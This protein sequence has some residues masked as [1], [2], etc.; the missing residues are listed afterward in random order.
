MGIDFSFDARVAGRYDAQRAHPPAVS[1]Q[2]GAT[3]AAAAGPGARVLEIGVGTGRIAWPVA[4]AGC[5][6][7]G[8]D[9]SD[10]M[11]REVVSE[12]RPA[13]SRLSSYQY[14]TLSLLQADMHRLPLRSRAFD[15]ALAVHVLHLA[16]DW[17]RVLRETTRLLRPGGAFIQGDDW[18]DPHSVV[19]RLRDELRTRAL[20]LSPQLRPPAAGIPK[21]QFLAQLGGSHVEEIVA[22]EWV[23]WLSPN[24]RLA[25]VEQ[26]MDAES[27][28]LPEALFTPLLEQLRAFAAATWDDL[29]AKQAVTRRFVLKV[30]RGDW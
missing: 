7:V 29:D 22:A 24:E 9:I 2:I 8:F 1:Q 19:G 28:F 30:T 17:R 27:W 4:A 6:V 16:Q 21:A 18:I 26:R 11:L 12:N 20:A 10:K 5:R 23:T 25:A 14:Q 13:L 3:I 15:A